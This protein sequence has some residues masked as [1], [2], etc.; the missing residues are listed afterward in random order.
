MEL[1]TTK[2]CGAALIC[3][4][5]L[6][7]V[8]HSKSDIAP[9]VRICITILF[10]GILIGM[11]APIVKFTTANMSG[12]YLGDYGKIVMKALG[13]VILTQFCSQICRDSGEATVASDVEAVGKIELLLLSLPLFEEIFGVVR[14]ILSWH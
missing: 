14:E 12:I 1:T 6:L 11:V 9:V 8:K 3:V 5:L 13:V 7:V 10:S 4:I 2:I